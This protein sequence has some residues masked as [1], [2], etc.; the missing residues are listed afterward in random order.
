MTLVPGS[1]VPAGCTT[2]ILSDG[3]QEIT[4]ALSVSIPQGRTFQL[5]FQ[6]NVVGTSAGDVLANEVETQGGNFQ[7]SVYVRRVYVYTPTPSPTPVVVPSAV[8]DSD[9][10]QE[11]SFV[12]IDVL[13]ND[14]GLRDTPITVTVESAPS[15]GG[16]VANPDNTI[17]YTPNPDYRGTDSFQYRVTDN[18]GEWDTGSVT[19]TVNAM[20]DT[21]TANDDLVT[22]NQNTSIDIDVL[23][24][25]LGLGD[26]P[27]T[28]SIP[29]PGPTNGIANVL[30]GN[31][32]RYMPNVGTYGVETFQYTVTDSGLLPGESSENSTA[33]VTVRV[34]Y[35]PVAVDDPEPPV[36]YDVDEDAVLNVPLGTGLIAN[37]IDLYLGSLSA[38]QVTPPTN[39]ILNLNADGSFTY[40][41]NTNFRGSDSFTYRVSD[42]Y[43]FSNVATAN[44][45]VNPLNDTPQAVDDGD[46][47]ARISVTEDTPLTIDVLVNDTGLGDTPLTVT[48]E[49]P[50]GNGTATVTGSPGLPGVIRIVYDPAAH[51]NGTDQF[52]YRVTDTGIPPELTEFSIGTVYLQVVPINDPPIADNDSGTTVEDVVLPIAID[53][54]DG[55]TDVDL[56]PI[57]IQSFSS[58]PN[59]TA[60]LNT[61]GTP[62]LTDDYIDYTPNADFRGIDSFTYQATDGLALSNLATV[63]ISVLPL[64]DTPVASPDPTGWPPNRIS[65]VED[66]ATTIFVLANDSGLGDTPLTVTIPDPPDHGSASI[67]GSPGLP[68]AI[69]I[70]YTPSLN[71]SG[72]DDFIYTVTDS[73][74][75]LPEIVESSSAGVYLDVTATND[76]PVAVDDSY[77]TDEDTLLTVLAPGVRNNDTDVDNVVPDDLSVFLATDVSDGDLTLNADGSF[78]YDPDQDFFG[79]DS[80]TYYAN[81]GTD[82]S[83]LPATVTITVNPVDDD[84]DAIDDVAFTDQDESVDIDVLTN[85]ID[86]GDEPLTVTIETFPSDG[87]VTVFGSPGDRWSI[88]IQYTPN[89]GYDG[90]DQFEYRVTDVHGFPDT[91]VAVVDV[92]INDPPVANDDVEVTDEDLPVLIDWLA[93]D[94]DSEDGQPDPS[95]LAIV[96]GPDDG[97]WVDHGDGTVTYTPDPDWNGIDSFDYRVQDSD[98]A[99][100]NEATVVITIDAVNDPPTAGD[101]SGWTEVV[102]PV[103]IN[104]LS[105]DDDG[106]EGPLDPGSVSIVNPPLK[107][108]AVPQADGSIT[109]TPWAGEVG[110]DTFTYTVD[111]LGDPLPPETSNEATVSITINT[112][113]VANDDPVVLG[114]YTIHEDTF[115]NVSAP[116]VLDNDTDDDGDSLEAVLDDDV[117]NGTL[118]LNP[119]GSFDYTPDPDWYGSDTFTYWAYDGSSYS[120]TTATVTITVN[121]VNDVPDAVDDTATTDED[122]PLIIDVVA[123]DLMSDDHPPPAS[124]DGV[125]SVVPASIPGVTVGTVVQAPGNQVEYIPPADY[126]GPDSFTYTV[127]DTDGEFSTATVSMTVNPINDPPVAEDDPTPGDPDIITDEDTPVVIDVIS[128]DSDIEDSMPDPTTVNITGGPSNGTTLDND[129][130]TVTFTPNADFLGVGDPPLV[131]SF[132]YTIDDF[133]G[134]TSNQATVTFT[135]T[136]INDPPIANDDSTNTNQVTPVDIYVMANDTDAEGNPLSIVSFSQGSSGNVSLND[137][138]TPADTTDDYLVYSPDPGPFTSDSFTYTLQDSIGALSNQATVSISINPPN[139]QIDKVAIPSSATLGDLITFTIAVW[140]DGP[141]TAYGVQLTDILGSCFTWVGGSPDGPLGDI[142][143][144][145]AVVVLPLPVARVDA[146][147][148]CSNTNQ[149]SVTSINGASASDTETISFLP[150]G[151]G[152]GLPLM[153]TS[154]PPALPTSTLTPTPTLT[155]TAVPSHSPTPIPTETDT[156][157]PAHSPTPIPTATDTPDPAHSPTPVPTST[158]TPDPEHSA[159]PIPTDTPVSPTE[160]P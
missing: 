74:Y 45:I 93:N 146:I 64:N 157:D 4:W 116:G 9:S 23:A 57:W 92:T 110:S 150:M 14:S 32:I 144:G 152:A 31:L 111:D 5:Q 3:R 73:A 132:T 126:F 120:P 13:A 46:P 38:S 158:D 90:I 7:T 94:T 20:N 95:T 72:L 75:A 55:D 28:V 147:S 141:G 122:I 61:N 10:V 15:N 118:N 21:P 81:D 117:D 37:D 30:P 154:A 27:I 151:G 24:N 130:G 114:D 44:L 119:D 78:T 80:F 145:G 112:P 17:T 155:E 103:N 101:D 48:I 108:N 85:D 121:S 18:D 99:W 104:V 134:A 65:V 76:P 22:T 97:G 69:W 105:N 50:A 58:P 40:T 83:L 107:G 77:T 79:S 49:T 36:T 33:T 109:Y 8:N 35:I 137:N 51:Y 26:I 98:G 139:L 100:S 2:T 6:A 133:D 63:T 60:V 43:A 39:G 62:Q 54:L 87:S 53:V 25:D 127:T 12:I 67:I 56:D 123:N 124:G 160:T 70:V 52:Q 148:S 84:P 82:D 59:G 142:E 106:S 156:P 47:L 131:D 41:P 91:D 125:A 42:G 159:T 138:G 113:P 135:I 140:N 149:A 66:T 88:Y 129:D 89:P 68:S 11:D 102:T 136:P 34:N 96:D 1:C 153:G 128:N 29:P 16:A 143:E 86:I 115:L 19:V 71:Y